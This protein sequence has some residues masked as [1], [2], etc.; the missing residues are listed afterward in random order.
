MSPDLKDSA[1]MVHSQEFHREAESKHNYNKYNVYSGKNKK[2][3]IRNIFKHL[4]KIEKPKIRGRG[5]A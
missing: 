2:I 4:E 5:P 3:I 1:Q